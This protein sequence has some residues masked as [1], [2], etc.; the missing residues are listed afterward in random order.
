[1]YRARGE[2]MLYRPNKLGVHLCHVAIDRSYFG[3]R[4]L[5]PKRSQRPYVRTR[6]ITISAIAVLSSN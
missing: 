4:H 2:T 6:K 1:M 3:L 5:W